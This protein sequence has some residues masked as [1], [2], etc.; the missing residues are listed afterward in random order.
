[1]LFQEEELKKL[2]KL[3][4]KNADQTQNLAKKPAP[5]IK[6]WIG[7]DQVGIIHVTKKAKTKGILTIL[8]VESLDMVNLVLSA[9]KQAK[10]TSLYSHGNF[11]IPNWKNS[12][13][14]SGFSP[15]NLIQ[16]DLW[17]S[18][19]ISSIGYEKRNSF[20][21]VNEPSE[22][23][24]KIQKLKGLTPERIEKERRELDE[25]LKSLNEA[26]DIKIKE[27]LQQFGVKP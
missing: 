11:Y 12:G 6:H 17:L 15:S 24:E 5:L 25:F 23:R 4:T 19:V 27:E 13:V 9:V 1:M 7:V 16:L 21:I 22:V 2:D 3:A 8:E 20:A 10:G 26:R 14:V 18:K